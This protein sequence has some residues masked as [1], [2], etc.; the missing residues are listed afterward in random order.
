MWN[1]LICAWRLLTRPRSVTLALAR[2]RPAVWLLCFG[3][4]LLPCSAANWFVSVG[5]NGAGTGR[6]WTDAWPDLSLIQWNSLQPGD[7]VFIAGGTYVNQAHGTL[8]IGAGGTPNN[9]ISLLRVRATDAAATSAPGWNPAFD[10]TV[11]IAAT[12]TNSS[13]GVN[14]SY[15]I[16]W[17]QPNVGSYVTIDGRVGGGILCPVVDAGGPG[18]TGVK[19]YTSSTGVVLSNIEVAGPGSP[20]AAGYPFQNEVPRH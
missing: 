2:L 12:G 4:C 7:T 14:N 20:N 9:P 17:N 6:N 19:L 11:V 1:Y 18:S 5:A 10:S 13:S 16:L 8:T 15:A 3:A